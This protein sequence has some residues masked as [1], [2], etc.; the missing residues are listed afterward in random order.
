MM[1]WDQLQILAAVEQPQQMKTSCLYLIKK[2]FCLAKNIAP[3]VMFV[4]TTI[5]TLSW[6]GS[7]TYK[8]KLSAATAAEGIHG[9]H[10]GKI[11]HLYLTI[12][13]LFAQQ[14]E[15]LLGRGKSITIIVF[16]FWQV[17]TSIF[18]YMLPSYRIISHSIYTTNL[19]TILMLFL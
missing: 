16:L 2:G 15:W 6:V 7:C 13:Y 12:N 3:G 1:S 19:F 14:A 9:D 18:L 10:S 5:L 11:C 8:V 17:S 4:S